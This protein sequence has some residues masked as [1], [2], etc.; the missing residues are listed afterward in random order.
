MA[1]REPLE[2]IRAGLQRGNFVDVLK[3]DTRLPGEKATDLYFLNVPSTGR[4]EIVATPDQVMGIHNKVQVIVAWLM[5]KGQPGTSHPDYE[6]HIVNE[7]NTPEQLEHMYWCVR[8]PFSVTTYFF[9]GGG[10][11]EYVNFVRRKSKLSV[12]KDDKE[13]GVYIDLDFTHTGFFGLDVSFMGEARE[14]EPTPPDEEPDYMTGVLVEEYVEDAKREIQEFEERLKREGKKLQVVQDYY[15]SGERPME[16]MS[17]EEY[18][19]IDQYLS[20]F[21]KLKEI[22]AWFEG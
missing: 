4:S 9:P 14:D 11:E 1:E 13:K 20:E 15:Y 17:D 19:L 2:Q 10:W 16:E 21:M 22:Q 7:V 12:L 3:G 5:H 8:E 6:Y 18:A